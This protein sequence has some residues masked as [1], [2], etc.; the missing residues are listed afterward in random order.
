MGMLFSRKVNIFIFWK[1]R[2]KNDARHS[3][4]CYPIRW[5]GK[6][7]HSERHPYFFFSHRLCLLL[8]LSWCH[9]CMIMCSPFA[10]SNSI[11]CFCE[12]MMDFIL[13]CHASNTLDW[14]NTR[15]SHTV[16]VVANGSSDASKIDRI[17]LNINLLCC[18]IRFGS[19][20]NVR[21]CS[22]V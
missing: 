14:W 2:T 9:E 8:L 17:N 11:W 7:G 12:E 16:S 13:T 6:V 21:H 15:C 4:P 10:Q 1:N 18:S 19:S 5:Y 22:T 20:R 3:M